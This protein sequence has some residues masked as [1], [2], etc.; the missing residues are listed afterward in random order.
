M[1][2]IFLNNA[3]INKNLMYNKTSRF[4]CLKIIYLSQK[5]RNHLEIAP[6]LLVSLLNL[7]NPVGPSS[8][9]YILCSAPSL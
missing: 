9:T 8:I 2:C 1:L 3:D 5:F 6:L 4:K 7:E